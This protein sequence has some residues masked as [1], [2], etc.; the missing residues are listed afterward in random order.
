MNADS[1][2]SKLRRSHTGAWIATY[3]DFTLESALQPIFS[4]DQ[5]GVLEL[6]AFEGL[7]RPS[8]NGE[9]VRPAQFFPQVAVE[10]QA[11]IDSLCRTL[12]IFNTGLLGRRKVSLF[13]NFHPGLFVTI[14]DI[15]REVDKIRLAVREAGLT[16]DQLACEI[17]QKQN[18]SSDMLSF[19]V[20][21]LRQHGFRI[22]IDEYGAEERDAERLRLL[23]PDYVKFEATWVKD[24][25]ENSAGSAL[26]RVM[27]EQF[28]E[29]GVT[30]IFEG[31]E[32][33]R[34]VDLC[35]ELDVPLLQGYALAR[36]QIAPTSFNE[37][38][39]EAGMEASKYQSSA[40]PTLEP[41]NP[42]IHMPR[43][44]YTPLPAS[45]NRRTAAFGKRTRT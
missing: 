11:M 25:L 6:Q 4:Q 45:T 14:N 42:D 23:K 7:I 43:S 19:F 39:P 34:Q 18:D 28:R 35:R 17:T 15:R 38:F 41:Y 31:L 20:K 13:V 29:Q 12:H 8:L 27:V 22:A 36:P 2:F 44:G 3:R 16:N 5:E 10:D 21:D 32:D 30:A 37:E 40:N 26:L 24:F 33:L 1:I 9:Q